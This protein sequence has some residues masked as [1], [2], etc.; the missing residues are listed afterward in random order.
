MP[1][2]HKICPGSGNAKLENLASIINYMEL[3]INTVN[4][5][6]KNVAL[7]IPASI[8]INTICLLVSYCP[9]FLLS[10]LVQNAQETCN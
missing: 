9:N 8:G 4:A 7:I 2:G 5:S 6:N 3:I 1:L 10:P